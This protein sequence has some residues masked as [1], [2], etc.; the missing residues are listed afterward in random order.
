MLFLLRQ[1]NIAF[2]VDYPAPDFMAVVDEE[3]ITKVI[4]NLMTNAV[5]YTND[6]VRLS[7][8]V[9]AADSSHFSIIVEDNG[10]GI[11]KD[12]RAKI[13]D[14][15]YQARDNKPG[16]GIGLS[17]VKTIVD[18][19]HGEVRVESEPGQGARFIV[20][21]PVSQ[22]TSPYGEDVD[23]TAPLLPE[24]GIKGNEGSAQSDTTPLPTEGVEETPTV[25]IVEDDADMLAF[26]ANHFANGYTVL[27][28]VNGIEGI[29]QLSQNVVSL[30][31]S[32]WMMPEM[33]GAEFCR[34][35]RA[36]RNTSH[37]PLIMLTAKTD[38]DSK[39][40]GMDIGADAYIE[41]PF[42]LKYLDA[43]I[44]NLISRR[45]ELMKQFSQQPRQ[46]I[47]PL[48]NSDIDN[49]FLKKMTQIIE[50][51]MTSPE[52]SVTFLAE[53][54]NIS[55]SGLFTKIKSLTDVTPNEMI[56]VVRLKKAA[57]LLA[58]G[59]YRVNEV[60]YMVGFSSPSYFTKCFQ[61]QFGKKPGEMMKS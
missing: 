3:G 58:E 17:I 25:L 18:Q 51:N 44:R 7:C 49:E 57:M 6:Q 48:A 47:D 8:H 54:L 39:S 45:R 38:D 13:F 52:L 53:Q 40:Q 12:D 4:S 15:F 42:S 14:A 24:E 36:N 55:R 22:L 16:T 43:C 2:N 28:A 50:E 61:K 56:Q 35:V 30:I 37:I 1:R 32:D 23:D 9:D 27:T 59:K 10:A 34:R 31:V 46:A 21:L 26:L 5:K 33:D 29:R 60:C 11:S 19:H 20:I 41:K